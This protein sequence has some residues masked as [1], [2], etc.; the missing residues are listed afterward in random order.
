M[1]GMIFGY[2]SADGTAPLAFATKPTITRTESTI[3][4]EYDEDG[5]VSY[6][7]EGDHADDTKIEI[8]QAAGIAYIDGTEIIIDADEITVI[9]EIETTPALAYGFISGDQGSW[10]SDQFQKE[11]AEKWEKVNWNKEWKENW[12]QGEWNK[13]WKENWKE[14]WDEEAWKAHWD[15][16]K[17]NWEDATFEWKIK[18]EDCEN[19]SVKMKLYENALEGYNYE[20]IDF[21]KDLEGHEDVLK[22]YLERI[23]SAEGNDLHA[24]HGDLYRSLELV[25]AKQLRDD[26]SKEEIATMKKEYREAHEALRRTR[27]LRYRELEVKER[28]VRSSKERKEKKEDQSSIDDLSEA[29]FF[30]YA[31]HLDSSDSD[32][33]LVVK[34]AP[35]AGFTYTSDLMSID[36]ESEVITLTGNVVLAVSDVVKVDGVKVRYVVSPNPENGIKGYTVLMSSDHSELIESIH[37]KENNLFEYKVRVVKEVDTVDGVDA[38]SKIEKRQ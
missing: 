38:K 17:K 35:N 37:D 14:N 18:M 25:R 3:I 23:Q 33:L 34:M 10:N 12:N 22:F 27:D 2:L 11:W 29:R 19:G 26:M 21:S 13:Q 16:N 6:R 24:K 20:I 30:T 32:N 7:I 9:E 4:R 15:E 31:A 36:S 8:D 1:E 28:E 5:N